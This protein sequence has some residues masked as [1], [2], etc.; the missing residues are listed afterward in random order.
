MGHKIYGN[1]LAYD[2]LLMSE[3]IF[4]LTLIAN[5]LCPG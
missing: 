4:L 2:H 5:Q 3:E 1:L